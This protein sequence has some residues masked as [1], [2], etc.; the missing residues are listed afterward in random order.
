MPEWFDTEYLQG[1]LIAGLIAAVVA[2]IAWL[3]DHRRRKR[4]SLDAVG[5]MNWTALFFFSLFAAV[6]LLVLAAIQWIRS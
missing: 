2:V 5:F 4:K 6:L 3:G 1:P